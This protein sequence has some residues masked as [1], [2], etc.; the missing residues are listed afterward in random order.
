MKESLYYITDTY[1]SNY[2]LNKANKLVPV[3]KIEQAG[4]FTLAK[5]NNIIQNS[6]KPMQRY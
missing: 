2:A 4:K 5:A 1:G 3:T 6:V